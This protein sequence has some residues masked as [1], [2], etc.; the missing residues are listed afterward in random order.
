LQ[1]EIPVG[2]KR[3]VKI[4]KERKVVTYVELSHTSWCL[5][6]K[7]QDDAEGSTHQFMGSLVFT[8]FSLEAYLNHIGP[9]VFRNWVALERLGPQD[10]L[11]IIAEKIGLHVDYG[12]RPWGIMK[13]LFG[14]RNDIAHGKSIEI[15]EE[16]IVP[17]GK[18]DDCI[19]Q[20]AKTKWEKFCTRQN[21][22]RARD[23]VKEIVKALHAKAE[24]KDE[25]PFVGGF[26]EAQATLLDEQYEKQ[27]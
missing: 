15:A 2:D 21:A 22:E 16:Q 26:Q 14:F 11:D 23:D 13:E 6:K 7:G 9:K 19:R 20:F 4:K 10:K 5:L 18:E 12:K 8:A 24:I 27:T 1:G 17:I 3:K 25:F